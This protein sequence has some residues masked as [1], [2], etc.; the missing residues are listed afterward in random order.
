MRQGYRSGWIDIRFFKKKEFAMRRI[1]A[2]LRRWHWVVLILV[3][4]LAAAAAAYGFLRPTSEAASAEPQMQTATV[5]QGD[6]VL[7]AS[8]TGTLI[9][10]DEVQLSFGAAG[11]V[12]ELHVQVGDKVQEGD[13]LAVEGEQEK[14]TAAVSSSQLEVLNAQQALDTLKAN[15]DM[16]KAQAQLDLANAQQ[17]LKDAQRE[18]SVA[19]QGNRASEATLEAAKAELALA[20]SN[21]E[22]AKSQLDLDPENDFLKL[23]VANAEKRYNSALWSWNWYNGQPTDIEQAQLEAQVAL[24]QAK[25]GEAQRAFEQVASGPDPDELAKAELQLSNARAS[26]E[27]AQ[28]NLDQ[29]V[30]EAPFSG[31]ILSIN[32]A[33]GEV[34]SG[35]F[36]TLADL[37]QPHIEFYLDETDLD[38]IA[39]GY[40]VEITFDAIPDTVFSGRV[41]QIDPSLYR[42]GNVSAIKALALVD[43]TYAGQVSVLPLGVS[44]AVDVIAGRAIGEALVPVEALR[45]VS[46][47]NYA[48]F[49]V[50]NGDLE[51]R[52]VKVDLMDVTY[53]AVS[54]GLQRG[55]VVSTGIVETQ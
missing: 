39:L 41:V 8:G 2:R 3:I 50:Q 46:P 43:D 44:A 1:L 20:E 28:S 33:V 5:R 6:L 9:S 17:D 15:A 48:V 31:T 19:Q 55:E 13:V 34:A 12:D 45:E 36:I 32:A 53:A 35:G 23:N 42:S 37:S 27:E 26:L 21:L 52:M 25:V 14:L 24:A 7:R 22:R 51:L 47:G 11:P 4:V 30:I 40:E 29:A 10:N 38:K 49:V 16:V 54:E 18:W